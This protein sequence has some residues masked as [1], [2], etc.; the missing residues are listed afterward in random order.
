MS[1]LLLVF[2]IVL[3]DVVAATRWTTGGGIPRK[4]QKEGEMPFCYPYNYT[5]GPIA[6]SPPTS[7]EAHIEH[8]DLVRDATHYIEEFYDYE[9][10]LLSVTDSSG[11]TVTF[12]IFFYDLNTVV[13][14]LTDRGTDGPHTTTCTT[15]TISH[16]TI[17]HPFPGDNGTA[18]LVLAPSQALL[19]GNDYRYSY[20][21][22][23]SERE[24]GCNH[25]DACINDPEGSF[26]V[27][28][29]WSDPSKVAD[30]DGYSSERPVTIQMTGRLQPP[31][32]ST[33]ALEVD[34]KYSVSLFNA[35]PDIE[36]IRWAFEIPSGVYCPGFPSV[37]QPPKWLSQV[38]STRVEVTMQFPGESSQE[39][40]YT[41]LNWYD[42]YNKMTRTDSF[43]NP[44]T[45][46]FAVA[47]LVEV[48]TI[49]DFKAG[50]E[51]VIDKTLGNCTTLPIDGKGFDTITT[52]DGHYTIK[53]PLFVFGL[54][55][56]ANLTYHGTKYARGLPC[57]VWVGHLDLEL[58]NA[59][60]HDAYL[61]EVYILQSGWSE[62]AGVQNEDFPVPVLISVHQDYS[63]A[64][65]PQDVVVNLHQNIF[66]FEEEPP[67]TRVYDITPCFSG[68]DHIRRFQMAFS[69][70]YRD[71]F[72]MNPELFT[73]EVESGIRMALVIPLI[74]LQHTE[75][76]YV[77]TDNRLVCEFALVDRPQV[78]MDLPPYVGEPLDWV[79]DRL[80]NNMD[81]IVIVIANAE[82]AQMI[83]P[84]ADSL[85][86][87]FE[88]GCYS[89]DISFT[90]QEET[91]PPITHPT[92]LPINQ[93]ERG[94]EEESGGNTD[95]GSTFASV[96]QMQQWIR[97]KDPIMYK[98]GDMAGM[99]M[100]MLV[101]GLLLGTGVTIVVLKKMGLSS[102][103]EVIPMN[104]RGQ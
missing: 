77:E 80:Q 98:P 65:L 24:I 71:S 17:F 32:G 88:D 60:I 20:V 3:G 82:G 75:I 36:G 57:D 51:Y 12:T 67:S 11:T 91:D 92:P 43:A 6:P 14:M 41:C 68:H 15:E 52:T 104:T 19:F 93:P 2:V 70:D 59:T 33:E 102:E 84:I 55:E 103:T 10:N 27:K 62:D 69:G 81:N 66:K 44:T 53:N 87:M 16:K 85:K 28:Y 79:V 72:D 97:G 76:E 7:Y 73:V 95:K 30:L 9:E 63:S 49:R 58:D 38:V 8:V 48:A 39:Y 23:S 5:C 101:L 40:A 13:Y 47:G 29:F 42:Y 46:E 94:T 61:Y 21:D 1:P 26:Y 96:V 64:Q 56:T 25:W 37:K 89:R 34:S 31:P 50:V 45:Q 83:R 74:R 4:A 86:E 90:H 78:D 99:A 22:N 100:G 18:H 35:N 54:E